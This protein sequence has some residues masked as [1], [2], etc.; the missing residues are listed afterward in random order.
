MQQA[1]LCQVARPDAESAATYDATFAIPFFQR[2]RRT[3][4]MLVRQYAIRFASAA[5]VGCRTG[6][7]AAYLSRRWR[8]PV[9]SL[10]SCPGMLHEAV[11][12]CV[13]L[14]AVLLLQ[15]IHCLCLP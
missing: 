9:F 13:G 14:N 4:E 2:I 12:N 8:V 7:F 11:R 3:F 5:D 1:I 10:D 6:L 15:D